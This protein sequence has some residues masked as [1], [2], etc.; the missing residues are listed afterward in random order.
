LN[1]TSELRDEEKAISKWFDLSKLARECLKS[2]ISEDLRQLFIAHATVMSDFEQYYSDIQGSSLENELAKIVLRY[3]KEGKPY[4]APQ[5]IINE[6]EH[7]DIIL[8][9]VLEEVKH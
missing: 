4:V 7:L 3:T 6:H 1:V 2:L 8:E 5:P 9:Q